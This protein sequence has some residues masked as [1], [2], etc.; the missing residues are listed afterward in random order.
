M[1]K[2]KK[3]DIVYPS[4]SYSPAT[5][6]LFGVLES[7]RETNE[8]IDLWIISNFLNPCIDI[9]LID[10]DQPEDPLVYEEFF[11]KDIW[12]GCPFISSSSI[13]IDVANHIVE[14][15]FCKFVV[16]SIE[17]GYYVYANINKRYIPN[18]KSNRNITHNMLIYG[19]DECN[20]E[21]NIADFFR[22]RVFSFEK[23]SYENLNSAFKGLQ[24]IWDCEKFS[25]VELFK[26]N[27]YANYKF[28]LHEIK[29]KLEDY[30]EGTD[31]LKRHYY[32][33]FAYE[34]RN[35]GKIYW[36]TKYYD[37]LRKM[38]EENRRYSSKTIQVLVMHKY[39]IKCG[40]S[41]LI[42]KEIVDCENLLYDANELMKATEIL[43]NRVIKLNI[44]RGK[45]LIENEEDKKVILEMISELE[46]M[47]IN[48]TK[49][50]LYVLSK[51]T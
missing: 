13:T 50:Y 35:Q 5:A 42:K 2:I 30:I 37:A 25:R 1:K 7:Y 46:E 14:G 38:L 6:Y 22:N 48:F 17:A 39:I 21:V 28:K 40:I 26:Y 18:Y 43:R 47:D 41:I 4:I 16:S 32:M 12:Y 11:R 20:K 34:Y 44:L 27:E 51:I 24:K 3:L 45:E 31:L 8:N 36:G 10:P 33:L 49:N 23:C 9:D 15:D 29:S 19:Y